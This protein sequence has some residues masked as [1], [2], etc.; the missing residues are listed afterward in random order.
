MDTIYL[1][2]AAGAPLRPE[3]LQ[4][5][6]PLMQDGLG[7]PNAA[8]APGRKQKAALEEA[9]ARIAA[10]MGVTPGEVLF[11]SGGTES[12]AWALVIGLKR[13]REK[14]GCLVTSPI[15]HHAVLRNAEAAARAGVP[16]KY[17]PV[18]TDGAV[19]VPAA[20]D[21]MKDAA[22]VSLMAVNNETGVVQPIDQLA[23]LARENGALFHTDAVQAV[24]HMNIPIY[25]S[26]IDYLSASAHKFG[27]PRGI[28]FM[29]IRKGSERAR[30]MMGGAQESGLRAGTQNVAGAVGMAA[31]L[32]CALKED[33]A[34][35]QQKRDLLE[36]TLLTFPG[37]RV[38]GQFVPRHPGIINISFPT[39]SAAALLPRLDMRGIC[40]SAGAA[41]TAGAAE[42]SHVLLAM[43][44]PRDEARCSL[45]FSLGAEI[46]DEAL[47]R[48]GE[49]I[50]KEAYAIRALIN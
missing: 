19:D 5:M 16:V 39:V 28:G 34:R 9:R 37:S 12:D 11:T 7:N 13:I 38:H 32:E 33:P 18:T 22:L 6:L 20:A 27:G 14:G 45:R 30:F 24:G 41:C 35:L 44:L 43:G 1:D 48:A 15:E 8:H 25:G 21:V 49:I 50:L 40:A 3:A 17:L 36:K 31:A 10:C 42:V 26:G 29:I 4:A 23:A 46:P 2:H 47:I